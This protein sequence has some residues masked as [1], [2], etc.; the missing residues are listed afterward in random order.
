MLMLAALP[1]VSK[2]NSY[3]IEESLVIMDNRISACIPTVKE[4][5]LDTDF[6]AVDIEDENAEPCY[7]QL[8]PQGPCVWTLNTPR[9]VVSGKGVLNDVLPR[10]RALH[11]HQLIPF[12]QVL[13]LSELV[14]CKYRGYPT[15]EGLETFSA[16]DIVL[17]ECINND[18][19]CACGSRPL[20]PSPTTPDVIVIDDIEEF[21][22]KD[23]S[24]D[25][26]HEGIKEFDYDDAMEDYLNT[27]I[28]RATEAA[29]QL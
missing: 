27:T 14:Q 24:E 11:P 26:N 25:D 4:P 21:D 10:P 19:L 29:L 5:M 12:D 2:N 9:G 1:N 7:Y 6:A 23:D 16:D 3:R 15:D 17:A 28:S 22:D 20:P 13:S 8:N 18:R